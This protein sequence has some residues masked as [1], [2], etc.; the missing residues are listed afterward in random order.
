MD[1]YESISRCGLL[2]LCLTHAAAQRAAAAGGWLWWAEH[3]RSEACLDLLWV[4]LPFNIIYP[5][6]RV[7]GPARRV[8]SYTA[9]HES[10]RMT[11]FGH[12][13]N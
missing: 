11:A 2:W 7:L 8:T 3:M 12:S 5:V 1:C 6:R 10:C 4:P 9:R 13:E